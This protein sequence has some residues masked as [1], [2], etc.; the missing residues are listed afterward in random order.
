MARRRKRALKSKTSD[1]RPEEKPVVIE[2]TEQ[3]PV[4]KEKA[5]RGPKKRK[6]DPVYDPVPKRS[7]TPS[8]ISTAKRRKSCNKVNTDSKIFSQKSVTFLTFNHNFIEI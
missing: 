5:K 3:K 2:M 7:K 8:L 6:I 4:T 1:N